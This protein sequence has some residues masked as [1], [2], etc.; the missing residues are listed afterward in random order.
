MILIIGVAKIEFKSESQRKS[1]SQKDSI[2][3]SNLSDLCG[4]SDFPTKKINSIQHNQQI[5]YF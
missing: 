1:E 4:L 2:R 5:T 3:L